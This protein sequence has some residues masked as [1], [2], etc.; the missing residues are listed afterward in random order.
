[1]IKPNR[2]ILGLTNAF[3]WLTV[4]IAF[5][6]LFLPNWNKAEFKY[7]P[8]YQTD[9]LLMVCFEL[10]GSFEGY[11]AT[12]ERFCEWDYVMHGSKCYEVHL[13]LLTV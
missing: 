8:F 9:G 3:L 7:T 4:V 2:G 6:S 1:M 11:L 13:K 5:V 10:Y 12:I